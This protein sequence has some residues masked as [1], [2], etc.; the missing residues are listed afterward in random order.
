MNTVIFFARTPEPGHGMTRL[1]K[2]V[3]DEKVD[4]IL[5]HLYENL[6]DTLSNTPYR[7][8]IH[9]N[10]KPPTKDIPAF[11]QEG[12]DLGETMAL[13]LKRELPQGPAIL[14]G[15]DLLGID[16]EYIASAFQ[17][18]ETSDVVLGPARDGGYG[19]V[20]MNSFV[21]IFS[22]ITYSQSDVLEK[23]VEKAKEQGKSVTLLRTVRDIDDIRDLAAEVLNSPISSY[24]EDEEGF[25]FLG[26]NR[27]KL[28]VFKSDPEDK[29]NLLSPTTM[30]PFFH[31]IS[32][33]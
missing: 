7:P 15:S 12:K 8:V 2:D 20:G 10:G 28:K 33:R 21:D 19:L 5:I 16:E 26:D 17:A 22:G 13:S 31:S 29:S 1:R 3:P 23:T 11:I 32:K 27:E 14:I 4:K 18:L 30:M 9:Y 24:T 25:I 6:Y